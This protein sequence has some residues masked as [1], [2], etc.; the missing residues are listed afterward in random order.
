VEPVT[1][2]EFDFDHYSE[3]SL[4]RI[5]VLDKPR[6]DAFAEAISE[7]VG[8][9]DRVVDVGAGS[10][11]LSMLAAKAGAESVCGLERAAIADVARHLV[12][13][14]GLDEVVEILH[15][16]A[17]T[18]ESEEKVDLIVSEWLGHFAFTEGMLQHVI[19]CRDKNLKPGGR[20]LPSGVKLL[21]APLHSPQLY[22]K[23]GPGSW[24][25]EVHGLDYSSLEE[26]EANQAI[27][28]KTFIDSADLL[29]PGQTIVNLDLVAASEKDIWQSGELTFVAERDGQLQGFAGWFSAQL[30]PSV[31]LDTAPD[32]PGTHWAQTYLPLSPIS[33][34]KGESIAIKYALYPHPVSTGCLEL[35][36]TLRGKR[37]IYTIT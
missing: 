7:V 16:N 1:T 5:M 32:K 28:V 3:L 34:E 15:E 35:E 18:Y 36:L 9:G 23:E 27:G 17:S 24:N 6:T 12:K 37:L 14:N 4:Q 31:C 13:T 10:G 33:V 29:A 25:I 30:S 22:E 19:A 26:I 2:A 21:L 20:M 8:T 11:L